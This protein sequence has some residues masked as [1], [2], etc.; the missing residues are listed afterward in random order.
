MV[1]IIID[2]IFWAYIF[3]VVLDIAVLVLAGKEDVEKHFKEM[4]ENYNKLLL[5]KYDDAF[6][7]HPSL[8]LTK[9]I[10]AV[11]GYMLSIFIHSPQRLFENLSNLFIILCNYYID[12]HNYFIDLYN[13][14]KKKK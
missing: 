1:Q 8:D 3:C 4:E 9:R 6:I 11:I 7:N 10:C 13:N 2:V 14:R 12:L 5:D